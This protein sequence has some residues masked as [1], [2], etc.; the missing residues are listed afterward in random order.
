MRV[1]LSVEPKKIAMVIAVVI[2]I[3]GPL[4][5][6]AMLLDL[7]LEPGYLLEITRSVHLDR[8]G[9]IP[10][11]GQALALMLSAVLLALV[12]RGARKANDRFARHWTVL[13]VIFAYLAFDEAAALHEMT[14][15]PIELLTETSGV[16]H[17]PWLIAG[18]AFVAVVTFA[19]A[20]FVMRLPRT[21]RRRFILAAALFVGGALGMEM[22]ES[23]Y[24]AVTGAPRTSPVYI[25]LVAIEETLE[26]AGNGVFI[27]AL[28]CH[29]RD[30]SRLDGV[31]IAWIGARQTGHADA[32]ADP[33]PSRG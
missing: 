19:F 6:V 9:N 13:A 31:N 30:E 7:Q 17:L 2:A 1:E 29:L 25:A 33:I 18:L 3:L 22:V 5:L 4:G 16:F 23:L 14:R 32:A 27:V 15:I 21:T 24:F 8:E 26:I 20:P 11:F 12:G 10:A 28:L